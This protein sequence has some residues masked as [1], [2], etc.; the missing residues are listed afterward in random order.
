MSTAL[1]RKVGGTPALLRLEWAALLT[2]VLTSS[3]F[4]PHRGSQNLN[5]LFLSPLLTYLSVP[6]WQGVW[7]KN[8]SEPPAQISGCTGCGTRHKLKGMKPETQAL[9]PQEN[10][11]WLNLRKLDSS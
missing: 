3:C 10:L 2:A 11:G 4:E 7:Q 8:A 1:D 9:G 5:P 6:M